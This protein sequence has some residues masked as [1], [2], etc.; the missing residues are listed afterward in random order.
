MQKY[1]THIVPQMSEGTWWTSDSVM[2]FLGSFEAKD[3]LPGH[4]KLIDHP[5][6]ES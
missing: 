4:K 1:T 3:Q 2:Y 5:L 6:P